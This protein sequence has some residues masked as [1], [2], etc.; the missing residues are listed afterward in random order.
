M[1]D[2]RRCK[3]GETKEKYFVRLVAML[4][5]NVISNA[6]INIALFP[7]FTTGESAFTNT[8]EYSHTNSQTQVAE[9]GRMAEG[10]KTTRQRT[11]IFS[12]NVLHNFFNICCYF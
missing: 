4:I 1:V 9:L 8:G 5:C 7:V 3:V 11:S 12:D 2:G 6:F 10:V